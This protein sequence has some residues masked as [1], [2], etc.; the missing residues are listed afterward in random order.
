M[1]EVLPRRPANPRAV[2]QW[3]GRWQVTGLVGGLTLA[4]GLVLTASPSIVELLALYA[5]LTGTM[6]RL[7]EQGRKRGR[8][9]CRQSA[10]DALES[11]I[12]AD[13]ISGL[14]ALASAC[15]GTLVMLGL[16]A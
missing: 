12:D 2:S 7:L 1:C 5:L 16:L 14:Y 15:I 11:I 3:T 8:R 6:A 10:G 9:H 4:V 13:F